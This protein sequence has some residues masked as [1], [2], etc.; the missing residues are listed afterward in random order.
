MGRW[1]GRLIQLDNS[2]FIVRRLQYSSLLLMRRCGGINQ[3]LKCF[4]SF[5]AKSIKPR[6]A[7]YGQLPLAILLELF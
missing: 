4:C 6:Y 5:E 2:T 3:C 7:L 1:V